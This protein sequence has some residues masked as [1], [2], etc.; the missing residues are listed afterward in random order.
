MD[1]N[2]LKAGE[3]IEFETKTRDEG[4]DNYD[5]SIDDVEEKRANKFRQAYEY[6]KQELVIGDENDENNNETDEAGK[7]PFEVLREKMSDVSDAQDG[8]V[9]KR[10]LIPGSGAVAPIGSRVRIHYNAYFEL[11]DEPFDSTYLRSR[12]LEFR[13]GDG[14]V[15]PGMDIAVSTMRK[16]EKAQF[17]VEP[18]YFMGERGCPPR[19]PGNLPGRF[20]SYTV[21]VYFF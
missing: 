6:R 18:N 10:V 3:E 11:N 12:S 2:L 4:E 9:V 19:V 21:I 5:W 16:L 7:T 14:S 15:V 20:L 1:I 8:G 13:I 17:I